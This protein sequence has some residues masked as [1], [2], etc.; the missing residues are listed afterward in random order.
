MR[1]IDFLTLE[2]GAA[3]HYLYHGT[4]ITSA[5]E[6]LRDNA[7]HESSQYEHNPTGVSLTRDYTVAH[8]F[9]TMWER[10]YP[11]VF[12]I[13]AVK[14]KR[15]RLKVIP[16]QDSPEPGKYR[17]R[18]EAEEMVLGDLAPL[19]DYLVSVNVKPSDIDSALKNKEWMDY[20]I[21]RYGND[22]ICKSR[23]TLMAAIRAFAKSPFLN[24]VRPRISDYL[25]RD[26]PPPPPLPEQFMSRAGGGKWKPAVAGA[27]E[28]IYFVAK[29][30]VEASV[31]VSPKLKKIAIYDTQEGGTRGIAMLREMKA[32]V[33]EYQ[34]LLWWS[35]RCANA[36]YWTDEDVA[37]LQSRGIIDGTINHYF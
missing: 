35:D 19:S 4:N 13:D 20:E 2:E 25:D 26:P 9:G 11:V 22:S 12:V 27:G 28:S 30:R 14:L 16:R 24:R 31:A 36:Q 15:S 33:P 21:E 32:A 8:R 23:R 18:E 7:I 10:E 5:I 37:E 6:I 17:G 3:D 29:N 34:V 1:W